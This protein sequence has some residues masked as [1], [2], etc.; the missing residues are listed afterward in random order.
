MRIGDGT[1]HMHADR[2]ARDSDHNV[3]SSDILFVG[4]GVLY[5]FVNG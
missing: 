4:R 3:L 1:H 5:L 2:V